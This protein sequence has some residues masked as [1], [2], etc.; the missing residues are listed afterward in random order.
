MR[1]A[2][3]CA[4]RNLY[5]ALAP[6]VKSLLANSDVERVFIL[7]EDDVF[8]YPLPDCVQVVNVGAQTFFPPGGP[9]YNNG[10]TWMVLM[11][12]ALHRV[13][14]D[15][16]RILS[17]DADTIVREDVSGLWRLPLDG[18]WIAGAREYR[19]S[20]DGLVYI[21]AGVM[22][23]NLEQLRADGKGDELIEAL[24]RKRFLYNEQDCIAE[25]C[26]GGIL[27]IPSFYNANAFT[28]PTAERRIEHFAAIHWWETDPLVQ[29]WR[30]RPWPR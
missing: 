2:C 20:K 28:E 29:E 11:R 13:F 17:L 8:P 5:G 26:Q 9:N 14:P 10:W 21:N 15:L 3:Y 1:A 4:T 7:A 16:D 18:Y 25:L 30:E 27:E 6:S 23:L 12:A 24:N 19:K 22:M